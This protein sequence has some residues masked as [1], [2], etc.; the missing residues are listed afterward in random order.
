MKYLWLDLKFAN[1]L[2]TICFQEI[3]SK[4]RIHSDST[5]KILDLK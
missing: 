2:K 4:A 3:K 5:K 1:P